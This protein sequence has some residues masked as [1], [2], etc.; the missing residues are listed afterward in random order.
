VPGAG[1][2]FM[3]RFPRR[4]LRDEPIA[5][6]GDWVNACGARVNACGAFAVSRLPCSPESPTVLELEYFLAHGSKHRARARHRDQSSCAI[7]I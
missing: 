5:P 6:C 2:A 3:F 4:Y 1:D 7:M